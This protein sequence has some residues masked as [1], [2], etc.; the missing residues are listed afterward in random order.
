MD[1]SLCNT[2][3]Y[4]HYAVKFW[5]LLCPSLCCILYVNGSTISADLDP[6]CSPDNTPSSPKEKTKKKRCD[7]CKKRVGLTGN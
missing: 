3:T 5:S 6:A 2:L 1:K 4:Y 7:T